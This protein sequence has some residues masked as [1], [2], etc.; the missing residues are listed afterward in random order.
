V[1]AGRLTLFI[2]LARREVWTKYRATSFG[3]LWAIFGPLLTLWI[4]S[5]F[6]QALLAMRWS[7]PVYSSVPFALVLFAGIVPHALVAECM[8]RAGG[9]VVE[10]PNYIKKVVFPLEIFL[11]AV[12]AAIS[13]QL[14]IGLG[15]L[16][17]GTIV[18]GPALSW[19]IVWM[20]LVILPSLLFALA[21]MFLFGAITPYLRDAG[22][23]IPFI[24]TALLFFSTAFIPLAVIPVEYQFY[25]KANPLTVTIESLR[26][27]LFL[28]ISPDFKIIAIACG[29]TAAALIGALVFF[30]RAKSGFADVV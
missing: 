3:L 8:S 11:L 17:A 18:F 13:V 24:S 16:I 9:L 25:I 7:Q 20:P 2:E 1:R 6:F 12:A 27:I 15:L 21:M 19:A 30:H 10:N 5:I 26:A 29:W 23:L 28:G 14:L 22:A 4:F